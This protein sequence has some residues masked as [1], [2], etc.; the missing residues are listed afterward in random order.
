MHVGKTFLQHVTDTSTIPCIWATSMMSCWRWF[1]QKETHWIPVALENRNILKFLIVMKLLVFAMDSASKLVVWG[2][3][4]G[5]RCRINKIEAWMP[6]HQYSKLNL[7]KATIKNHQEFDWINLVTVMDCQ[8]TNMFCWFHSQRY[9]FLSFLWLTWKNVQLDFKA[10][11]RLVAHPS[12]SCYVT[13]FGAFYNFLQ[14]V[15]WPSSWMN[16]L[17]LLTY[18]YVHVLIVQRLCF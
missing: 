18:E 17:Y 10:K 15:N 2:T 1:V 5:R 9:F 13:I 3:L 7:T 14:G 11:T 16:T 12:L 8:P 6:A 4:Y